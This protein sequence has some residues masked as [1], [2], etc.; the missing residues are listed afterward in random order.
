MKQLGYKYKNNYSIKTVYAYIAY[1]L[2]YQ[3]RNLLNQ[4][5]SKNYLLGVTN[6]VRNMCMC[7][8]AME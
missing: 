4:F 2:D 8:L 3:P 1:D 5:L 7:I 6:I